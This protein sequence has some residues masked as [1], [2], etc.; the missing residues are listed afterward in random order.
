M[1]RTDTT[2]EIHMCHMSK[3]WRR[4]LRYLALAEDER[5]YEECLE[6]DAFARRLFDCLTN[7]SGR[8][9]W[10]DTNR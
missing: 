10:D 9:R 1:P 3:S 7:M 5:T 4:I 6:V 2:W 8:E